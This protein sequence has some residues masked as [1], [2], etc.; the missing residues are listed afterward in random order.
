MDGNHCPYYTTVTAAVYSKLSNMIH[1]QLLL[2][3]C[4]PTITC[5][6]SKLIEFFLLLYLIVDPDM[7]GRKFVLSHPH[8]G[9]MT[10][11]LFKRHT[12]P[13]LIVPRI[14]LA[15]NGAENCL[16]ITTLFPISSRPIARPMRKTGRITH[17]TTGAGRG[18]PRFDI[19]PIS[20]V[21]DWAAA[22]FHA[23]PYKKAGAQTPKKKKRENSFVLSLVHDLCMC[24]V[25]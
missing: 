10:N 20:K 15:P 17:R 25:I 13:A 8:D 21:D 2:L 22:F 11:C 3:P 14:L 7:F 12:L 16:L 4:Q 5:Y 1:S 9:K 6:H 24:W 23:Q 19:Q 18:K